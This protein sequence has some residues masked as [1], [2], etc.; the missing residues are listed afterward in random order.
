M[1]AKVTFNLHPEFVI[2]NRF[3]TLDSIL[4]GVI[5]KSQ[6]AKDSNFRKAVKMSEELPIEKIFLSDREWFY[7]ASYPQFK[8]RDFKP[9]KFFKSTTMGRYLSKGIL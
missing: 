7:K 4:S 3:A 9:I 2:I 8:I 5:F 1:R 6:Y